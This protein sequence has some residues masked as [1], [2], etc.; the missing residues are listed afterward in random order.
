[1]RRAG[2]AVALVTLATAVST[3]PAHAAD[4]DG[5]WIAYAARTVDGAA[6]DIYREPVERR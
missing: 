5:R 1:M 4:A 3:H 6:A 2:M